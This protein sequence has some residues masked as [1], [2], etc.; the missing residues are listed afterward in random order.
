[1]NQPDLL[2]FMS[3]QHSPNVSS[4]VGG[5]AQT[6]NLEKLSADGVALP[7]PIR[8]VRFVSRPGHRCYWG[9]YLQKPEFLPMEPSR[10]FSNFFA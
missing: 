7:R 10:K 4:F 3:D 9:G 5:P 8:L 1:M 2:V 6:P